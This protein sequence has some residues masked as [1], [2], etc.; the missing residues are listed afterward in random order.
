MLSL[1]LPPC[2][3]HAMPHTRRLHQR[4]PSQRRRRR[5]DR[6]LTIRMFSF[7]HAAAPAAPARSAARLARPLPECH[8]YAF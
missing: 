8:G 2:F 4:T 3:V 6:A 7:C 1:T 5:H